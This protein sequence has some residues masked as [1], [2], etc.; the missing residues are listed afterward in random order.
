M[1]HNL[2]DDALL[3]NWVL[4]GTTMN[5][6]HLWHLAHDSHTYGKVNSPS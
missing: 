4:E 5:T 2:I 3:V 6:W 1:P